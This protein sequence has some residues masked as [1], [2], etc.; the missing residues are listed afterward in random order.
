MSARASR[1]AR[2]RSGRTRGHAGRP[3]ATGLGRGTPPLLARRPTRRIPA[4]RAMEG[5]DL[6]VPSRDLRGSPPPRAAASPGSSAGRRSRASRARGASS[7]RSN[8]I[9]VLD[10][11]PEVGRRPGCWRG[12]SSTSSGRRATMPA[13]VDAGM[14]EQRRSHASNRSGSRNAGQVAPGAD[15]GP[16]PR[17][18]RAPGPGGSAGR[19]RPAARGGAG[20]RRE[21]VMIAPL[22]PLDEA[23]WS[24]VRLGVGG[25]VRGG[26][27]HRVWRVAVAN[28]SR[29]HGRGHRPA[30]TGVRSPPR[31]A[32]VLRVVS[33]SRSGHPE[34]SARPGLPDR[35][36]PTRN[37]T[38]RTAPGPVLRGCSTRRRPSRRPDRS[39]R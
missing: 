26:R 12:V 22:R 4:K 30:T 37:R 6:A 21:G 35:G 38:P 10:T 25:S 2:V 1:V 23:R 19:P 5:A 17:L 7:A 24:T 28:C 15:R 13:E 33:A 11:D 32:R 3:S 20:Q 16:G 31:S 14:D 29:K 39:R 34:R 18:A 36:Q 8:D 9:A 27:A